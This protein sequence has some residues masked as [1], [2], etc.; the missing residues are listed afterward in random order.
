MVPNLDIVRIERVFVDIAADNTQEFINYCNEIY[1]YYNR[2]EELLRLRKCLLTKP[3]KII[4]K[5]K[6]KRII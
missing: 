6:I 4:V 1:K 3:I 5:W 2:L